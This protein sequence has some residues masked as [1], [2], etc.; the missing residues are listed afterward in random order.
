MKLA[1]VLFNLGGPDSPD[2]VEPFLANLF[3][4]PAVLTMPGFV[5][6]PLARFIA[7]KRAPIA[8]EIYAKIGGRSPIVEET[9]L[10]AEAL[11]KAIPEHQTRAFIAMRC[12]KP[13]THEAAAA[14][15]AFQ[16][17][18]I[19]LLPLYPQFST[20]TTGSSLKEWKR[21]AALAGITAPTTTICCYPDLG[22]FIAALAANIEDSAAEPRADVSYRLLLSAHGLPKRVIARGDPYQA[23]VEQTAAALKARLSWDDVSICYQSKVGPLEWIGPATDAEIRRAGAEGKGVVI[24]PIAFV[25]EHSETL[26]ELDIEYA[27]LARESGVPDYRRVPTVGVRAEFIAGLAQ[28]V[29]QSIDSVKNGKGAGKTCPL[30][31]ARCPRTGTA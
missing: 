26:V 21:V 28:L 31:A 5:R 11:E 24:A 30:T 9:L 23:Q 17:D 14:V 6:K 18:H 7:R 19:V 4:D 3:S 22:G 10:Q 12:W 2:A 27:K 8:R 25:S 13:F 15:A 29:R 20:T 16:P 1:V